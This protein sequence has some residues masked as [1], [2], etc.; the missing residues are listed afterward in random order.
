VFDG[1]GG[2][3]AVDFVSE[4]LSKNVVSAVVGAAGTE[5]RREASSE[6]D[7]VSAA[8]KAAYLATDSELLTQ[9]Q[10]CVRDSDA[11]AHKHVIGSFLRLFTGSTH[12][13]TL[14]AS[15]S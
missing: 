12:F 9:H 2:R 3:A 6:E 4:R 14:N 7:A 10:V 15:K 13:H 11:Y 1:H 5:T 8:I